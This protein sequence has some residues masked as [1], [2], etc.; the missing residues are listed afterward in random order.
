MTT[1]YAWNTARAGSVAYPNVREAR[2]FHLTRGRQFFDLGS[3]HLSPNKKIRPP[4]VL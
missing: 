3:I 1:L 2:L 4:F